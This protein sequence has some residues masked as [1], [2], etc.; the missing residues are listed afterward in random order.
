MD[1][2]NWH[3][4]LANEPAIRMRYL[5][6]KKKFLHKTPLSSEIHFYYITYWIKEFCNLIAEIIPISDLSISK[7]PPKLLTNKV[8]RSVSKKFNHKDIFAKNYR[9]KRLVSTLDKL[10]YASLPKDRERIGSSEEKPPPAAPSQG[11]LGWLYHHGYRTLAKR[12]KGKR[13]YPWEAIRQLNNPIFIEQLVD[14]E[15]LL[16]AE[17]I[18]SSTCPMMNWCINIAQDSIKN[19]TLNGTENGSPSLEDAVEIIGKVIYLADI[20]AAEVSQNI[21]LE[22]VKGTLTWINQAFQNS[23]NNHLKTMVEH[24]RNHSKADIQPPDIAMNTYLPVEISRAL[25][26][27]LGTVNAG[28]IDPLMRF[29]IK[30]HDHPLNYEINLVYGLKL[31]YKSSALREKF[32]K[33]SA[34]KN[35]NAPA[36]EVIRVILG[37]SNN[38]P[39][40]D[41]HAKITALTA[42]LSHLR[43]SP[44]GSCFA[45]SLA[46]E[47]LSSQLG[48]CLDDFASLL[49]EGKLTRKVSDTSV[50]FPFLLHTDNQN[51]DTAISLNKPLWRSPGLIAACRSLDLEN[52]KKTIIKLYPRL[53]EKKPPKVKN[54]LKLLS[55]EAAKEQ[56]KEVGE[57]FSKA[58]FAFESQ[59]MNPLLKVWRNVIAGMAEAEESG[60]LKT[61]ILHSVM[62][63]LNVQFKGMSSRQMKWKEELY[64]S[65]SRELLLKMQLQYDPSV[66]HHVKNE[67]QRSLEGGFVLYYR[68]DSE[69]ANPKRIDTPELFQEMLL[70]C[71]QE[72]QAKASR[73]IINGY[74]NRTQKRIVEHLIPYI[75]QNL[76]I[77]NVLRSYHPENKKA[78][79]DSLLNYNKLLYTP[80]ITKSGNDAG[81]VIDVYFEK[82]AAAE[83]E[84]IFPDSAEDLL[85]KIIDVGKGISEEEKQIISENPYT[86]IPLRTQ[87]HHAFSLMLG[88]SSLKK[89]WLQENTSDW[90][91]E[92]VL[93]PGLEISQTPIDPQ[94][95][96]NLIQFT[97]D[98]LLVADKEAE[99]IKK[100]HEVG[101]GVTYR[102]FRKTLL[103]IIQIL[104][105]QAHI[106]THNERKRLFDTYLCQNL[107]DTL[108]GAF[109]KSAV[110]FADTN[111]SEG[112]HDIHYCFAVN[113]GTGKLE[114]WEAFD[115]GT[116][117]QALDQ[118]YWMLNRTWELYL[119]PE[120]FLTSI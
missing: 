85:K 96:E 23:L 48:L 20:N 76:F 57:L 114:I 95:R 82:H 54:L 62:K 120:E 7:D 10:S 88:H 61:A 79:A 63:S 101:D 6:S 97:I 90:I 33:I 72:V 42:L 105:D 3:D 115:N 52:P 56:K 66:L 75:K 40:T 92:Y 77:E 32:G 55:E 98:K 93:S 106:N 47:L 41:K 108:Q 104:N 116:H 103:S 9:H 87:G 49:T 2:S 15:H 11:K 71:L 78:A 16:Q 8:N 22:D 37:L 30:D 24:Y 119:H 102:E 110:H 68:S 94:T 45:E 27:K 34:P 86:L 21:H 118:N 74:K 99:F 60:M 51:L 67:D 117:F 107:P 1:F 25:I 13:R 12:L 113:P 53:E 44:T 64:A 89:A 83:I 100:I 84:K 38:E 109:R 14:L 58:C 112:V 19:S 50:D 59:T 80:W 29:F 46:I 26:T 91:K 111:W 81:K 17:K 4:L 36:E 31:L 69:L 35:P 73:S 28:I 18:K 5:F 70:E 43:Q 65:F 39:I